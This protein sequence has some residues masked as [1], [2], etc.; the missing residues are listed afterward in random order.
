[1]FDD[2]AFRDLIRRVRA[3]DEQAAA[4]LVR[5]YEL[6]I[7]TQIRLG[8]LRRPAQL[9]RVIDPS[10]ICQS[11]LLSFFVRAAAGQYD[12]DRPEQLVGLLLGMARNKLSEQAKHH[13]GQRRDV[14][15]VQS[16]EPGPADPVGG[17]ETPSAVVSGQEL[18]REVYARLSDE[19][20]QIADLRAT[21]LEWAEVAAR[22]G[23]TPDARRK[24]YTRAVDR[25]AQELGLAG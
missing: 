6:E 7:L 19:E 8:L 13:Q 21:G 24:Q 14:R 15:R 4:E 5:H 9:R 16:L 20:R 12:L 1:M 2:L 10:D 22:L 18:L 11:V 3:G 17:E 23:G 25:A